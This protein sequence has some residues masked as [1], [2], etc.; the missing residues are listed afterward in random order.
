MNTYLHD[1]FLQLVR[2]GIGTSKS[3]TFPGNV[4]WKQL[5]A[6]ADEQGLSAVILDALNTDGANF[7]DTMPLQMKLEWIGEVIQSYEQR[8]IAYEKAISSLAGFYNQLGFKMMVLKGYACSL[9][10]LKPEHRP[11]GDIDIWQFGQFR[12]ADAALTAWFK[13]SKG[14]RVQGFEIDN[15]HHHH[16]VFKWK[17][18][19][20]ENHY[21]FVNVHHSKSNAKIENVF[22]KLG[23]DYS[24]FVEVNG[25]KVYLPSPNLH[26]LFLLRHA[27][28]EFAAGGINL[29][30][31]LDWAFFV[32]KHGKEVDWEWLENRLEEYGMK[33]LYDVFNAIC[34]GDLGFSVNI[35]TRVQFDPELKDRVLKE[36]L[37]PA[38]PNHKPSKLLQRVAWKWH[39]WKANEWKHK[40]VYKESMWS[41][42]WSGVWNHL[43]KPASI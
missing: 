39:R 3:V 32:E 4:D 10:W 33:R 15:S 6:L 42:F 17:G 20:V 23:K 28:T 35:F 18:F 21:D 13:S 37:T 8:Y 34:V 16:T 2:L 41:A 30:Q 11:C 25:E 1:S 27:M 26:A 5:K 36:I 12:E 19:T 31:L 14:S 29:R 43:L 40:L 38:V 22:K 7:T 9:D 24:H